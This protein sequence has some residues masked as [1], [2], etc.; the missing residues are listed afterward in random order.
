MKTSL[1]LTVSAPYAMTFSTHGYN[2]SYLIELQS[3]KLQSIILVDHLA[4]I[5]SWVDWTTIAWVPHDE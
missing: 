3:M 5:I 4:T 1:Y 2:M